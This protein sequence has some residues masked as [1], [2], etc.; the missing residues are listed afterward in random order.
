MFK[1]IYLKFCA[2][3]RQYVIKEEIIEVFDFHVRL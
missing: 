1:N 3:Y 2:V